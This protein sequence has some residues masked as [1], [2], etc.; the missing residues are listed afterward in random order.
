MLPSGFQ[1]T[2]LPFEG[3]TP[4]Q[5]LEEPTVLR[6]ASDGKVFVGEKSGKILVYD[7]LSDH[8]PDALRRPA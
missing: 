1:A 7:G 3:L 5:G 2:T 8:E 6:F 4:G